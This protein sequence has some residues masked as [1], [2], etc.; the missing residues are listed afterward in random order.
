MTLTLDRPAHLRP[1]R[2]IDRPPF[3]VRWL[4]GGW[5]VLAG[6]LLVLAHGCHGDHDDEPGISLPEARAPRSP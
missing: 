3:R 6:L 2:P 1:S 4:W 5:L